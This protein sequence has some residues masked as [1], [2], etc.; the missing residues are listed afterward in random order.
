MTFEVG[1]RRAEVCGAI[2]PSSSGGSRE[3]IADEG[4]TA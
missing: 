4:S 3:E 1:Y 2:A